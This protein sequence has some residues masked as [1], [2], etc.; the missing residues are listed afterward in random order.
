MKIFLSAVTSQFKA[1]RDALR[2]DLSA[3]GAEVVVQEDWSVCATR[4][5]CRTGKP[6]RSVKR[7]GNSAFLWSLPGIGPDRAGRLLERFGTVRACF[8]AAKSKLLK[9]EGI[10]PKTAA[11][12]DQVIN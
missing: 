8:D 12:I 11:A 2:S 9:V 4:S 10:G 3:V 1:C 5:I 6:K 7:L